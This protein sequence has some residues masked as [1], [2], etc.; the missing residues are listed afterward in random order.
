MTLP[1][2]R[3]CKSEYNADEI[4]VVLDTMLNMTPEEI[5]KIQKK[6]H[7]TYYA[8]NS[9]TKKKLKTASIKVNTDLNF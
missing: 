6:V 4:K 3:G 2:F 1:C 5:E 8:E 9:K 7:K